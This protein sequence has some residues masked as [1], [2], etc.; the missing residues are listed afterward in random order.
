[1]TDYQN[2]RRLVHYYDIQAEV[3]INMMAAMDFFEMGETQ[4]SWFHLFKWCEAKDSREKVWD[5]FKH[6]YPIA[7]M[8]KEGFAD[9]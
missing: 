8:L 1:M 4:E 7:M 3:T 5:K 2:L 6:H 9:D